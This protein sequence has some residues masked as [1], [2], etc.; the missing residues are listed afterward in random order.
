MA[1]AK[2]NPS[3]RTDAATRRMGHHIYREVYSGAPT[4]FLLMTPEFEILDANDAYLAATMRE[5]ESLAGRDM[6]EAFP[7]NPELT[8][9]TG[10]ANLTQSL[11][12]ARSTRSR[13]VM[14]VQRY[15]VIDPKCT[16]RLRYW[17][18]IN[19]P[20][21]DA[22]GKVLALV[23]HVVNVTPEALAQQAVQSGDIL[24]R[25]AEAACAEAQRIK[26]Q[27]RSDI[28]LAIRRL[29]RR[30]GPPRF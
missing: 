19:W 29:P 25:R 8:E 27:I 21:V 4:P 12:S 13:H 16:W 17:R 1:D 7:D 11:I 26:N 30:N 9:A 10:V 3:F 22:D 14:S 18:P 24:F 28:D 15:D 20:V 23:H 6:F 5:R 2:T